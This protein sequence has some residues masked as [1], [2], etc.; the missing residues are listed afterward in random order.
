LNG[1]NTSTFDADYED[2]LT[3][4]LEM[5]LND[6]TAGAT[7][8]ITGVVTGVTDR[9]NLRVGDAVR[10]GYNIKVIMDLYGVGSDDVFDVVNGILLAATDGSTLLQDTFYNQLVARLGSAALTVGV[11]ELEN[12][13]E[14]LVISVLNTPAPSAQPSTLPK[15]SSGSSNNADDDTTMIIITIVA[16]GFV[17]ILFIS[18]FICFVSR[19]MSVHGVEQRA[20][21]GYVENEAAK[22]SHGNVET[23]LVVV[24]C[25][26]I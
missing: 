6:G 14:D 15:S 17:V 12:V 7:V 22:N 25:S 26:L 23:A 2:A 19:N 24:E 9:R 21:G 1:V 16:V 18:G 4:S 10:V 8:D 11:E 13:E 5:T 20:T 3:E